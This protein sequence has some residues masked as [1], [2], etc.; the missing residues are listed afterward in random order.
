MASAF[1]QIQMMVARVIASIGKVLFLR[2]KRVD[3][4]SF[5]GDWLHYIG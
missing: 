4:T 3:S 2:S 1:G 5:S